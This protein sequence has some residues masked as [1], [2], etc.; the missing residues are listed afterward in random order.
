MSKAKKKAKLPKRI[1]GVK[2]PKA[3][4]RARLAELLSSPVGQAIVA[5]A[6]VGAAGLLAAK[7]KDHPKARHLA[8]EAKE[9]AE[10]AGHDAAQAG[11]EVAHSAG[12]AGATLAY[13]LSEAAHAFAEALRR[14]PPMESRSFA[15]RD[16]TPP[17]WTPEFTPEEPP[18]VR[19]GRKKQHSAYEAGPL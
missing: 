1:A 6:I 2:V 4:R 18:P 11:R 17:A 5:D 10:H 7:A 16:E 8:H 12:A 14:G 15:G 19:G 13:A 9:G 3:L